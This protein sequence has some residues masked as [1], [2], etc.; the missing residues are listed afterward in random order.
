MPPLGGATAWL[1]SQPL[2]LDDLRG[3]VV[4]VNFRTLTCINWL[5][6]EPYVRA[7]SQAY[8]DDGLTVI[9]VHTPEF[10]F[11]H[12]IDLVRQAARDR[13][14]DYPVATGLA[15]LVGSAWT[16]P[17]SL[18]LFLVSGVVAGAG[19]GAIFRGSLTVVIQT[20]G[21]DNR[22]GALAT[23]FTVGYAGLSIPVVGLG[24]AL[25]HLSPQATLLYFA[26][27]VALGI[28]AAAPTLTRAPCGTDTKVG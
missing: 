17:P 16:T 5:R 11:E 10:S 6:Q 3:R 7:W 2:A 25:E 20:S 9:G 22:A 24:L 21:A 15:L 8:R 18:A 13:A 1:N 28:L 4:L 14:I 12:E 23:F 26:S 19:G 27:A